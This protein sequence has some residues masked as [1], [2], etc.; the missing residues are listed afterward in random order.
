MCRGD[1]G[2]PESSKDILRPLTNRRHQEIRSML[3]NTCTI[4]LI[5]IVEAQ[6]LSKFGRPRVIDAEAIG[7]FAPE[8]DGVITLNVWNVA[9]SALSPLF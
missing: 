2:S 8:T 1:T 9:M 3:N 7:I 4:R 5:F 6:E